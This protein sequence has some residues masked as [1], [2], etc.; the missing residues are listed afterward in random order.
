VTTEGAAF[1][2]FFGSPGAGKGTLA[3]M[4]VERLGW[5][6]LSTGDLF[7]KHIA[8]GTQLGKHIDFVIKSGKLVD[9]EV[10]MEM[11]DQW[12]EE[13]KGGAKAFIFDG[14]PRTLKQA[15]LFMDL[16][17]KKFSPKQLLVVDLEI[18]DEIV[19]KRLS[20]R[21]VCQDKACQAV[22][23]VS[24][25]STVQ[26][27]VDGICDRCGSQLVQREDD[28]AYTVKTRLDVYHR[29]AG[30]LIEFFKQREVPIKTFDAQD[31]LE[32]IFENF[33]TLVGK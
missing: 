2:L 4:C 21:R 17:Q 18:S 30:E 13:K 3:R 20:S 16:I 15:R 8:I 32:Q 25:E 28:A 7:R 14:F 9:D 6:Q 31:P 19:I 27:K 33:V 5:A 23:S 1:F 10:V 24:K 29:H 11:V 22:Y 12:I 26:S